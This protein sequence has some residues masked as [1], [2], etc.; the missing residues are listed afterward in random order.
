MPSG[1]IEYNPGVFK[2]DRLSTY[3]GLNDYDTLFEARHGRGAIDSLPKSN[4][5]V[6]EASTM[7]MPTTTSSMGMT[8]NIMTGASPKHT[9]DS[10]H[11]PPIQRGLVSV[12][13]IPSTTGHKVVSPMSTGHILGEGSAIFIDMTEAMLTTLDQQMALSEEAWKPKGSL[14]GNLLIPG[15]VSSQDFKTK[16]LPVAKEETRYPDLYLPFAENKKISDKFYGYTDSMSADGNPVILV[17]LTAL[18]YRYGT[19][20]YAVD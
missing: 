5:G 11:L 19:T 15:Q 7:V 16:P 13:E 3:T 4:E 1:G 17:E 2:Q 12:R 10:G 20:I 9:P 14:L 6:L 8:E 18:T